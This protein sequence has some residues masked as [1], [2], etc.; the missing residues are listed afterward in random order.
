MDCVVHGV[1]NSRSQLNNFCF[2]LWW[3]FLMNRDM[4]LL[5]RVG[6]CLSSIF[7]GLWWL[8]NLIPARCTTGS[9]LLSDL[10]TRNFYNLSLEK[11][12]EHWYRSQA[13][14]CQGEVVFVKFQL[15]RHDWWCCDC[16]ITPLVSVIHSTNTIFLLCFPPQWNCSN[17]RPLIWI[18]NMPGAWH[19]SL[20]TSSS[21]LFPYTEVTLHMNPRRVGD[22]LI[23]PDLPFKAVRLL[24]IPS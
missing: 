6:P 15:L 1:T 23:F 13:L 19:P 2:Q 4:C 12:P 22:S 16:W 24:K 7:I 21:C 14:P 3:G 9:I 5:S 17:E 8:L 11:A 18:H 20:Q 10:H